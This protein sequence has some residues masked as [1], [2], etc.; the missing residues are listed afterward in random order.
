MN[1]NLDFFAGVYR[2][3]GRETT[4]RMLTIPGGPLIARAKANQDDPA[5]IIAKRDAAA[6]ALLVLIEEYANVD[7]D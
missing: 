3:F 6:E 4:K 5:E 1:F 7:G 2:M